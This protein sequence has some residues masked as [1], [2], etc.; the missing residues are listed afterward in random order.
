MKDFE[1]ASK[2]VK[3]DS[4]L[5]KLYFLKRKQESQNNP[6]GKNKKYKFDVY[7]FEIDRKM[8]TYLKNIVLKNLKK[9]SNVK[10]DDYR[11]IVD[12]DEY[13][14]YTYQLNT[15]LSI[16]DTVL[17]Q[18]PNKKAIPCK[19]ISDIVNSWGYCLEINDGKSSCYFFRHL[20]SRNFV[21]EKKRNGIRAV[22][23]VNAAALT[24]V[25]NVKMISF[26]ES[27]DCI[28]INRNTYILN[29]NQFETLFC[30][31]EEFK[32]EAEKVIT[33]LDNSKQIEG[34]EVLAD[35][36]EKDKRLRKRLVSIIE[37]NNHHFDKNEIKKIDQILKENEGKKL[38]TN[39][40]GKLLLKEKQ[41]CIDLIN[42]LNDYYKKG[43]YSGK[44]YGTN[45]GKILKE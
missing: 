12:S 7:S 30:L 40:E 25:E 14:V 34:I 21:T 38:K 22:F 1:N 2:I 3:N 16:Y 33:M 9:I 42:V 24:V 20:S 36:V 5:I 31:E 29:K 8:N 4:S 45:S 17:N 10:V 37:K 23:D 15:N 13:F 6:T 27:I 32:N 28:Y 39:D 35:C 43:T 11:V 44:S 19:S 18:I 41:D 26:D